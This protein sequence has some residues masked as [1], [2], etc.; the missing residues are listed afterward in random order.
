MSADLKYLTLDTKI[1]GTVVLYKSMT[2]L[3]SYAN[4]GM[5]EVT[6]AV[7]GAVQCTGIS[8]LTA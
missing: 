8:D 5:A 2:N 3:L 7:G 1:G 4:P 6:R